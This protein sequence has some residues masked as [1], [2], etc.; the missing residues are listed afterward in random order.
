MDIQDFQGSLQQEYLQP[1]SGISSTA[2]LLNCFYHQEF[3]LQ[4]NIKYHHDFSTIS[5]A[6]NSL[7]AVSVEDIIK[8]L[9]RKIRNRGEINDNLCTVFGKILGQKIY[10]MVVYVFEEFTLKITVILTVLIHYL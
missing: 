10:V 3:M 8:P 6:L 7:A 9:Y 2:F 4:C 1:R 5:G